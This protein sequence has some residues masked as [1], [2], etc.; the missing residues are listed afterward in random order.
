MFSAENKLLLAPSANNQYRKARRHLINYNKSLSAGREVFYKSPADLAY[1]LRKSKINLGKS[2]AALETHI[3]EESS[4]WWDTKADNIFYY[5]QGKAYAY[6]LLF[7]ALGNDYKNIIVSAGQY[8]NWIS[9]IKALED[10]SSVQP[11]HCPQRRAEQPDRTQ[12]PELFKH[13]HRESPQ[14]AC[15]DCRSFKR[16]SPCKEIKC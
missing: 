3:R 11:A 6:Y 7:K 15:P 14:S 4:S 1:L 2:S 9:L 10:A 16:T 13:V 5:Q 8:Q 12:P